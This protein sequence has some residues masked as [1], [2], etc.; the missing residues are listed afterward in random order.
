MGAIHTIWEDLLDETSFGLF[1]IH[2]QSE[3]HSLAYALNAACGLCL[4]RTPCDLELGNRACFPVFQWK[5]EA[6][7]QEW[8]LFRNT[9]WS[10]AAGP[11]GG[12]FPGQPSEVRHYLIP[13][14]REVD[15]FLKVDGDEDPPGLL[16]KLLSIPRLVTAY[17]LEASGLKSKYNLVY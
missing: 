14:K 2:C 7:Y 6:H 12:L 13:E 9:G 4:S 17:R 5:D 3:D 11:S 16:E 1:A 15:Y 8:T 10:L